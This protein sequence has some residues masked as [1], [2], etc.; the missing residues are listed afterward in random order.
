MI[1]ECPALSRIF[2]NN[3]ISNF[4]VKWY[5]CGCNYSLMARNVDSDLYNADMLWVIVMICT[6]F[7]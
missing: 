1:N 7:I 4:N 3:G 5:L 2:L 6:I